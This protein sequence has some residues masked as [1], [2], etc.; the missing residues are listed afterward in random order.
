MQARISYLTKTVIFT[1]E[2]ATVIKSLSN[3]SPRSEVVN[4]EINEGRVRL[5]PRSET[6]VRLPV[7][8]EFTSTEGLIDNRELLPGVYLAR[9]LVRVVNGCAL[10]SVLSTTEEEVNL[11]EP[12]VRAMEVEVTDRTQESPVEQNKNRYEKILSKL[13]MEHFVRNKK[14]VSRIFVLSIRMCFSFRGID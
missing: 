9:S 12:V 10:T 13:R 6:I 2:G 5:L 14:G 11:L 3:Q 8:E 4:P 7:E 1:Y